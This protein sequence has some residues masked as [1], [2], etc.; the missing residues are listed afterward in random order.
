MLMEAR[1]NLIQ[2]AKLEK[3]EV[4]GQTTIDWKRTYFFPVLSNKVFLSAEV[5]D[6]RDTKEAGTTKAE[7]EDK[8]IGKKVSFIF[9]GFTV[10]AEIIKS[11][12]NHVMLKFRD[13][14]GRIRIKRFPKKNFD[15]E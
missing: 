1:S 6:F 7:L 4:I 13:K 14:Y 15:L 11:K 10:N 12:E 2:N 3:G 8:L 9:G 5:I